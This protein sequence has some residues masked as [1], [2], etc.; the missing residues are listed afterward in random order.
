MQ[1]KT[2]NSTPRTQPTVSRVLSD[3][4]LVE[5][6][7]NSDESTTAL[8]ISGPDGTLTCRTR[9]RVKDVANVS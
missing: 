4:T 7:Y 6:V 3:G 9:R 8:A 5:L 2:T 1:S